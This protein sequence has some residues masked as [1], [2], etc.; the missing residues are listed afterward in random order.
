MKKRWVL[1]LTLFLILSGLSSAEQVIELKVD[2]YKNGNVFL[3]GFKITEG[4]ASPQELNGLYSLQLHDE[5]GN[6]VY[7]QALQPVHSPRNS[8]TSIF[9]SVP[10]QATY[11]TLVIKQGSQLY[12]K[13]SIPLMLCNSD[14]RCEAFETDETC[15]EDCVPERAPEHSLA[16]KASPD[17]VCDASCS[18]DSNCRSSPFPWIYLLLLVLIAGVSVFGYL[19]YKRIQAKHA[20][21][22]QFNLP[23]Q[24][25][26]GVAP[27]KV[28]TSAPTSPSVS[29]PLP[30][31]GN[32]L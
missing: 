11:D 8:V 31:P 4:K 1:Y 16:Y 17:G 6:M 23:N 18:T 30:P 27:P 24:A 21:L 20:L 29:A 3:K 7:E 12:I 9:L 32:K 22:Q 26:I 14:H 19:E 15:A 5:H 13:K 28:S 10:Y 2:F 25:S